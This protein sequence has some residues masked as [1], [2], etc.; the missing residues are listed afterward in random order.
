MARKRHHHIEQ[1]HHD[2]RHAMT[3]P[4]LPILLAF[5]TLAAVAAWNLAPCL[6]LAALPGVP[7]RH[8][9]RGAASLLGA[10]ARGLLV[11]LPDLLAPVVVPFALLATPR[12]ADHL[13]RWAWWWDNDVSINGDRPEYWAADYTGTTYYARAHPRSI[14]ARWVW[15]GLRNRA[16]ALSLALG[17][18]Y[19][20]ADKTDREHWGDMATGRD[21][22]GWTLNRVGRCYQLYRVRR[23]GQALCLRVNVGYKLWAFGD[24]RAVAMVVNITASV[25]RWTGT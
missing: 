3:L 4:S 15:L 23:I 13:P 20:E 6:M 11:L 22:A 1:Q 24:G 7:W 21:H 18:R 17:H 14:W 8:K 2:H 16:S 25:I 12:N 9:L 19:T 5:A 10:A